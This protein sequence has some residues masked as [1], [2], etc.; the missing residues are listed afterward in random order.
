MA[1]TSIDSSEMLN[2][3]IDLITP[4]NPRHTALIAQ[5]ESA[6]VLPKL[7]LAHQ[8]IIL[9][10]PPNA[11]QIA[12]LT[13]SLTF[14]D[15]R[16]DSLSRSIDGRIASELEHIDDPAAREALSR[17]R[18]ALFPEG[19]SIN[20]ASYGS[21]AGEVQRRAKRV[22][23]EV[24]ATLSRLTT[25]D[26]RT[27]A[28]LY[29]ELQEVATEIGV[30][31]KRRAALGEEGAQILKSRDARFAWIRAINAVATMLELAGVDERPVLGAIRDAEVE[32][33]RAA[34]RA[35]ARAAQKATAADPAGQPTPSPAPTDPAN[36]ATPVLDPPAPADPNDPSGPGS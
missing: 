27:L 6:A 10:Q 35:A 21:Q 12:K 15:R 30:M 11:A 19:L 22:D 18:V 33:E 5:P 29:D 7:V 20:N 28:D 14:S 24:R 34:A 1:L 13:A 16:H 3:S 31:E 25:Y 26:G 9:A 36:P 32:A 4:G 8:G 23:A 2:L 17:A